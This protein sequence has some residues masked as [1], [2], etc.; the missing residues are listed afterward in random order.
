MKKFIQII[1]TF[2]I[3]ISLTPVYAHTGID[4]PYGFYSGFVHPWSGPDHLLVMFAVGLYAA[5]LKHRGAILLPVSFVVFM[6][7]GTALLTLPELACC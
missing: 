2:L 1:T 6:M 3:S 4:A 5:A 7:V